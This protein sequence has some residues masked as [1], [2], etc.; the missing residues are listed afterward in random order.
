MPKKKKKSRS[1]AVDSD[2]GTNKA[3]CHPVSE[4][5]VPDD[6]YKVVDILSLTL[7]PGSSTLPSFVSKNETRSSS[8]KYAPTVLLHENDAHQL[9]V[10][11]G[12]QVFVLAYLSSPSTSS[13]MKFTQSALTRVKIWED[14][15]DIKNGTPIKSPR[16]YST[17][18]SSS[19]SKGKTTCRS[20]FCHLYP[21]TVADSFFHATTS[22]EKNNHVDSTF[23]AKPE[24]PAS[25]PTSSI[26]KNTPQSSK[27]KF[28]FAIGGGGWDD[29]MGSPPSVK[30]PSTPGNK[31]SSSVCNVVLVPLES[32]LGDLVS[33]ALCRTA[34]SV[35]MSIEDSKNEADTTKAYTDSTGPMAQRVILA[36]VVGEHVSN[37]SV[38]P[39]SMR[40]QS[41]YCRVTQATTSVPD[42]NIIVHSPM[43][44]KTDST[45]SVN[46]VVSSMEQLSLNNDNTKNMESLLKEALRNVNE[47]QE[48][49]ALLL[50]RITHDTNIQF[51]DEASDN[52]NPIIGESAK[53]RKKPLVVGLDTVIQ[54]VQAAL[55]TTLLHSEL[56]RSGIPTS[57]ALRPPKGV[58]LH[59]PSGVGKSRLACQVGQNFDQDFHVD[60]IHCTS[61]QS[62]TAFVGQAEQLLVRLFQDAQRPRSG[63]KGC[64]LILDDIHL[65]CPRRQGTN[66]GADRLSS[67][68]LALLDGIDSNKK[69]YSNDAEYYPMAILA[70]TTNPGMLDAALRRPGRLDTEIE[71]S[72]PDEPPTRAKIL[73]F[74]LESLGA[75]LPEFTEA[76]WLS[77]ARLAKGFT[78]ADLTLAAKE[79]VRKSYVNVG[80]SNPV[81]PTIDI[82]QT[83][84]RSVKPSAIKAVTVE[85]PRVPWSSIGGMDEVKTQLREAIELPLT[86][87]ATFRKLGIRPPRGVLLYGPPGCSKTLMARAL[88]TEGHMNFLAVKGP[89]LLSKW[90]GE[91]ERALAALFRRA[92]LASPAVIFFDEVDAIAS[93]RGGSGSGG[94]ERLLSQ[95]LTELDGVHQGGAG[96]GGRVVIVCATNRPDLLDSALMR[97]G[98]IDRMIYVGVPDERSR[99]SILRIGLAGKSCADD[100]DFSLL[101]DEKISGGLSGAELIAACRDAA[102]KAMEEYEDALE[103]GPNK[104]PAKIPIIQMEQLINSLVEMERQITSEVLE[105]YASFQGKGMK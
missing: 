78:G 5:S 60:S 44:V 67:T 15:D 51:M 39:I 4:N 3:S 96:E 9:D 30:S 84:I 64:L 25:K 49:Q 95:L 104:D 94:G 46:M 102:L 31:A 28:S 20:G 29:A 83:A 16:H 101:V 56:F 35:T 24:T 90:L 66:V 76:E 57:T 21:S 36:H 58:L 71:V 62:Q 100:I 7:T 45:N 77:L 48:Q 13:P 80:G 42:D 99:E 59:G 8:L 97:P 65:I 32:N 14:D 53:I 17:P 52:G 98:R 88:A 10:V 61:L 33:A 79:A 75:T 54:Q 34:H 37:H 38:V 47:Q 68:L 72:I 92:R 41:V 22:K 6:E 74:Q 27:S 81:V 11:N 23:M 63:K 12:D 93:K 89:E 18:T 105:F 85:V 82:L 91:S 73:Q 26:T 103:T 19:K 55:E 1:T 43:E 40:G 50:F 2:S 86:H 87:A 70:I 69:G